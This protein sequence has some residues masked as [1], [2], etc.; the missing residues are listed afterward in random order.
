MPPLCDEVIL[1][2]DDDSS[3]IERDNAYLTRVNNDLMR[4]ARLYDVALAQREAEIDALK[5]EQAKNTRVKKRAL[6]KFFRS[7][8][9]HPEPKHIASARNATR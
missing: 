8:K 7:I 3:Q 2:P 9:I 4:L 5:A 1:V 6:C